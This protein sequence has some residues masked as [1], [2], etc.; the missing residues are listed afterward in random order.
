[1]QANADSMSNL[2]KLYGGN[3]GSALKTWGGGGAAP[4]QLRGFSNFLAGEGRQI[5]PG[6]IPGLPSNV[7]PYSAP[8]PLMPTQPSFNLFGNLPQPR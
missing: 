4:T 8:A 2:Q 7:S 6:V 3:L 1:M 5:A